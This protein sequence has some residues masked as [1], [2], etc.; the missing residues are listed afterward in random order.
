MASPLPSPHPDDLDAPVHGDALRL[1]A[2]HRDATFTLDTSF[3][4]HPAADLS[5]VNIEILC[6]CGGPAYDEQQQ[7]M[8]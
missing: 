7:S 6:E 1:V 8:F 3:D 2:V 5:D 4:G